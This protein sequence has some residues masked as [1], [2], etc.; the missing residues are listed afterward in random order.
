M[1]GG[2]SVGRRVV[3]EAWAGVRLGPSIRSGLFDNASLS[4][5]LP[6]TNEATLVNTAVVV[7]ETAILLGGIALTA[8]ADTRALVQ[9]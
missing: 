9:A 3:N 6:L 5:V 2:H 1:S 4:L 8:L 7:D